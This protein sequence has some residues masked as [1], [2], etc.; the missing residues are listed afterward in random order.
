MY[1]HHTRPHC[2]LH[3]VFFPRIV[4]TYIHIIMHTRETFIIFGVNLSCILCNRRVLRGPH[5]C[6]HLLNLQNLPRSSQTHTS[7]KTNERTTN[8]SLLVMDAFLSFFF[9]SPF[10]DSRIRYKAAPGVN[11]RTQDHR[12]RER[13]RDKESM[14]GGNPS[15]HILRG[16]MCSWMSSSVKLLSLVISRHRQDTATGLEVG[17]NNMKRFASFRNGLPWTNRLQPA[18]TT[19]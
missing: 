2:C 9:F 13:E 15:L 18:L 17:G 7:S 14:S 1:M 19:S 11:F 10:A 5:S 6:K 4:C 3:V 12:Q 16:T 8:M